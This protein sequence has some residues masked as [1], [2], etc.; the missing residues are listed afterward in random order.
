MGSHSYGLAV[1]RLL[2]PT[3]TFFFDRIVTRDHTKG[4]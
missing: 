2:D 3:G 1:A 4:I